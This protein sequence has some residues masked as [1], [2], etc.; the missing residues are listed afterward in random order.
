MLSFTGLNPLYTISSYQVEVLNAHF[1]HKVLK[2]CS[3][4]AE[5]AG[6]WLRLGPRCTPTGTHSPSLPFRAPRKLILALLHFH[7]SAQVSLVCVNVITDIWWLFFFFLSE[8][9]PSIWAQ[10]KCQFLFLVAHQRARGAVSSWHETRT[11]LHRVRRHE[12]NQETA[13]QPWVAHGLWWGCQ[14]GDMSGTGWLMSEVC[15]SPCYFMVCELTP[16]SAC[17]NGKGPTT[18]AS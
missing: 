6:R 15:M 11:L 4:H 17:K 10:Y 7:L 14:A 2:A 1:K 5:A 8:V 18:N 16:Y 3:H 13:A 12:G 9:C